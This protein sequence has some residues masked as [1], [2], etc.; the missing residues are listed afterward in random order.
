MGIEM[1]FREWEST[2]MPSFSKIPDLVV[3]VFGIIEQFAD[4]AQTLDRKLQH[5]HG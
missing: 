5:R 1:I 2:G 3:D 4:F